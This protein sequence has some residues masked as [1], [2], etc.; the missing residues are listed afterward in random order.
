MPTKKNLAI[1]KHTNVNKSLK[2]Q[3]ISKQLVAKVVKKMRQKK[4]KII[5]LCPFA[6]H[7]FNKTQK[8]NN[9]RS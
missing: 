5:P 6:K 9:I 8:Y 7:K 1:I 3:K 4:Q 2:K